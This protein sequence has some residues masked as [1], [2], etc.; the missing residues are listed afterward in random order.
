MNS[1]MV[2]FTD[3]IKNS[4]LKSNTFGQLTTVDILVGLVIAYLIGMFIFMTYRKSFRGVVYSF[5]FNFSLVLMTMVTTLV[6]MTIS[7]NI[8]LS[9]GMVGALSIVRFRT[10]VK[11]PMDIVYMF[12][13]ITVGIT[14]GAGLYPLAGIGSL[15]V[16]F[17]VMTMNFFN[18]KKKTY[19]LVVNYEEGVYP[20][21]KTVLNRFDYS[22][23]SKAVKNKKV[24]LTVELK[25]TAENTTFVE[26]ISKIEG[27]MDSVLVSYD[28]E[29]AQ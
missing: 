29:Y 26:E 5:S 9:L 24:E 11:D 25:L 8:V 3:V 20:K 2:N 21:I 17:T 27:V 28:G 12:W 10:A 1:G 7:S 15:L 18:T 13:A 23:K 4:V 22:V 14:V 19:I 6:I 16:G